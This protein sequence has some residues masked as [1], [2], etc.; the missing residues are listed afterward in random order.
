MLLNPRTCN[1]RTAIAVL[2]YSL[3]YPGWFRPDANLEQGL[4][5]TRIVSPTAHANACRPG[6]LRASANKVAIIAAAER[7]PWRSSR[8]YRTRTAAIPSEGPQNTSWLH[9]AT[10]SGA[11][12]RLQMVVLYI[13]NFANGYDINTL[14]MNSFYILWRT[15]QFLGNARNTCMQQ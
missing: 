2:E 9:H 8:R 3:L 15:D 6:T 5:G 10:T 13:C 12:I 11:H 4:H 1:S 14:R 7:E